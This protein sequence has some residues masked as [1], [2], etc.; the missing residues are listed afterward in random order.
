MKSHTSSVVPDPVI[1]QLHGVSVL[2]FLKV[3][4]GM[5][6]NVASAADVTADE[7]DPQILWHI[8]IMSK[9]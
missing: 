4:V 8:T 2:R 7:T 1:G 5:T 3:L 9:V 6:T